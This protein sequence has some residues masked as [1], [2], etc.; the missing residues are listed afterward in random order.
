MKIAITTTSFAEYDSSPLRLLEDH[1]IEIVLNRFGRKLKREEIL[2]LCKGALGIIAGT[3]TIDAHIIKKLMPL[4]VISRCG[5]GL[6]NIDIDAAKELGVKVYSTPEAPV[7]AVAEL[8]MGLIIN[9]LRKI[10]K[11]ERSLRNGNW[12]KPMG[13]MLYNKRVG[14]VGF[15]EIARCLCKML[16]PFD[17]EVKYADPFLEDGLMG[18][19][20]IPLETLLPW[21]DIVTLH[22]S[23]NNTLLGKRELGLMKNGAWLI[24]TSRGKVVDENHLCQALK[25]GHL[26]GAAIDVFDQEPYDGS[27]KKLDNVLL[28]PHIGSYAIEARVKM[29]LEAAKNL[30]REL[31]GR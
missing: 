4:R 17:C 27:L 28:T 7:Q 6:D 2:P 21:A 23:T 25:N 9:L 14:I 11:A 1:G 24:N 26:G 29:E 22:V 5:R 18:L 10:N 12:G 16:K 31:K 8:T 13:N 19:K 15:G 3:E 20:N 30:L